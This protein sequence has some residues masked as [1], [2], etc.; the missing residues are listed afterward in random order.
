LVY[1]SVDPQSD[2]SPFIHGANKATKLIKIPPVVYYSVRPIADAEPVVPTSGFSFAKTRLLREGM[3]GRWA[4]WW[5]TETEPQFAT[6]NCR[7]LLMRNAELCDGIESYV[8]ADAAAAW[9]LHNQGETARI[10]LPESL[11]LL[12]VGPNETQMLLSTSQEKGFQWRFN[13]D[14][15]RT[16][17]RDSFL[18]VFGGYL[19]YLRK[20]VET[21][22]APLDEDHAP[23]G[24]WRLTDRFAA[25]PTK[26]SGPITV[27]SFAEVK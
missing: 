25:N 23:L 7:K 13:M 16:W 27:L 9:K 17:Y 14:K 26:E 1:L 21:H 3:Q 19:E 18:N 8:M 11:D 24:W 10:R 20:V 15:A 12:V 2:I 6:S 4:T 22:K 5:A